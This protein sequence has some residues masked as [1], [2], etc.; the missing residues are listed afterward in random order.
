MI[1]DIAAGS[2]V[3]DLGFK[4]GDVII[5]VGRNEVSD[6]EVLEKIL[7]IE[8][9]SSIRMLR[10]LCVLL[11]RRLRDADEKIIGWYILSGG[12]GGG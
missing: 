6:V 5:Q 1:I 10:L 2:T 12:A 3:A 4:R 11:A 7:D 9:V 8:T